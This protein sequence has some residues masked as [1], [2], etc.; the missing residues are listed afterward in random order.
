MEKYL[1][2]D[3]PKLGF[4]F[5]RLPTLEDGGIDVDQVNRMVDDFM[6]AGFTY[7]DTAYG[8]MKGRSEETIRRTLV[9][10]YPRDKFLLAT[11]L[12]LWELK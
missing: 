5:M 7:F 4:G 2:Y 11:K 3:V 9:E 6:G 10:R 8:Y 12:P 1:G